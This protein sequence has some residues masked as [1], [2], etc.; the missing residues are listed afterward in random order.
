MGIWGARRK[1]KW[2]GWPWPSS[3][4]AALRKGQEAD[5]WVVGRCQQGGRHPGKFKAGEA[6]GAGVPRS[7][8]ASLLRLVLEMGCGVPGSRGQR[9]NKRQAAAGPGDTFNGGRTGG[10]K[11]GESFRKITLSVN[12][13]K[14]VGRIRISSEVW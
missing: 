11:S 13:G 8:G 6:V 12:G 3:R 2:G 5:R 1:E 10:E 9:T 4:K 14:T 7:G